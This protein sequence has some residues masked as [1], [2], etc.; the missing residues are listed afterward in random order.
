M[1]HLLLHES[2]VGVLVE[3]E[4]HPQVR[5]R[6]QLGHLLRQLSLELQ[7]NSSQMERV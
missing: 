4:G 3:G 2:H 5:V 1:T 7:H 6:V